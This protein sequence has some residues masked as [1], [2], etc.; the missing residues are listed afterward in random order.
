MIA[1]GFPDA[2][3][4][5][6]FPGRRSKRRGIVKLKRTQLPDYAYSGADCHYRLAYGF[7]MPFLNVAA[8]FEAA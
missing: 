5:N 2:D 3:R 8:G 4:R 1:P 6:K 7:H